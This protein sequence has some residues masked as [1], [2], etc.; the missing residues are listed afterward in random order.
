LFV[1]NDDAGS[2]N[3]GFVTPLASCQLHGLEP[4]AYLRDLLCLLPRWPVSRV[5]ALAPVHWQQTAEQQDTQQ[6]LAADISRKASLGT[7]E[8]HQ[9][10]KAWPLRGALGQ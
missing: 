8:T 5:L 6:L 4:W 1:G 10:T 7:L 2:I 9:P 3:A